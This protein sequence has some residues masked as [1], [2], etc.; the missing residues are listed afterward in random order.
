[1]WKDEECANNAIVKFLN[2]FVF[3]VRLQQK[4]CW[5]LTSNISER[6]LCPIVFTILDIHHA[7]SIFSAHTQW[8]SSLTLLT[9]AH[10]E[11]VSECLYW[12]HRYFEYN[13]ESRE[14]A[15]TS[16][17]PL[18]T[19]TCQIGHDGSAVSRIPT[20]T[21]DEYSILSRCELSSIRIPR[22]PPILSPRATVDAR[23]KLLFSFGPIG[24]HQLSWFV[25][26]RF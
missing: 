14:R 11:W 15:G 1:M 20:F 3:V 22:V 6:T 21:D 7:A 19:F 26:S 18:L 16:N 8:N 23:E 24:S 2:A 17:Y 10:C 25:D 12:L 13:F 4:L 5:A 9:H